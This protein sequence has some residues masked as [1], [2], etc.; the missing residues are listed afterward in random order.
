MDRE[1]DQSH[2]AGIRGICYQLNELIC[3]PA[4]WS[5]CLTAQHT[6]P[7]SAAAQGERRS[8]SISI[9]MRWQWST[10]KDGMYLR[11]VNLIT[12]FFLP[13]STH[14]LWMKLLSA[15]CLLRAIII[16]IVIGLSQQW[17]CVLIQWCERNKKK[18]PQERKK[19]RNDLNN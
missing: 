12:F 19:E 6:N 11:N 18:S 13:L 17:A 7:I 2:F 4:F 3:F 14:V 10:H 1:K 15:D 5:L 8:R 9:K 16:I